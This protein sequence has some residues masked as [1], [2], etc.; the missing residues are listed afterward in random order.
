[1]PLIK[2]E[3]DPGEFVIEVRDGNAVAAISLNV[4]EL[5]HQLNK[6]GIE[7]PTLVQMA[8]AARTVARPAD[9]VG[10]LPDHV[11]AAKAFAAWESF[12]LLGNAPEPQRNSLRPTE[13][14]LSRPGSQKRNMQPA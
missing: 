14:T 8:A 1:M 3:E 5:M 12:E 7:K 4:V 10:R 2:L 6:D 11:M 13:S 9:L